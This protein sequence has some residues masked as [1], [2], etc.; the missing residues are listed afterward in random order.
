MPEKIEV[1][2]KAAV[3]LPL[4]PREVTPANLDTRLDW[5]FLDL[6]KAKNTLI[7]KIG[8]TIE[9]AMREF[10]IKNEFIEIHSP[11]LMGSQSETGAELF[12]VPYF[13]RKAYLAQSPQFYKQMAIAAG[14]DKVFEI[15]QVFRANPSETTRHDTEYTSIDM[16]MAWIDSEEDIMSFEENWLKY[17]LAAVKSKYGN[18]IKEVF[19]VDIVP[20]KIPFPRVTMKEAHEITKRV[21]KE[22]HDFTDLD[23]EGERLLS[24]H[25]LETKKHE[26]VFITDF[27]WKVRPFYH[28][29]SE[30]NPTKAKGFDLLWKG[31]EITTGAQREHRYETLKSQAK[32][33]GI[34]QSNVDFYLDFFKY[35]C[36]PHGGFGFGQTRFLTQLLELKNVREATFAPHDIKRLIP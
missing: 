9:V 5:R 23:P 31:V 28:M 27:P 24:S 2:S 32:E 7:F 30:S 33:K 16:E 13:G 34:A 18:E 8:T 12:E 22:L 4:D 15:G 35:G 29:K 21:P 11:K 36:P 19:G 14:F 1:V 20:P 25:I 17:A 26:F 3:P 10:W 6:R